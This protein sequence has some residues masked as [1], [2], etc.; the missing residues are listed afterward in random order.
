MS[1][2]QF[3]LSMCIFYLFGNICETGGFSI[4]F[5]CMHSAAVPIYET[6]VYLNASIHYVDYVEQ[7][8]QSN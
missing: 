3:L 7:V 2:F 4:Q 1:S 8:N 5:G 6:Q